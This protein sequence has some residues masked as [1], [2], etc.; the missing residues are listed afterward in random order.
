M[1][2]ARLVRES[3]FN[4]ADYRGALRRIGQVAIEW[5][6]CGSAD[7]TINHSSAPSLSRSARSLRRMHEGVRARRR[8]GGQRAERGPSATHSRGPRAARERWSQIDAIFGINCRLALN[9]THTLIR[10]CSC[11][12]APDECRK[13][14]MH[15]PDFCSP[16]HVTHRTRAALDWLVFENF[17]IFCLLL[18]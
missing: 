12:N 9:R 8:C 1:L 18:A 7:R 10:W 4:L 13:S 2:S 11:P 3:K 17:S 15:A 6:S 5:L 16:V 14:K